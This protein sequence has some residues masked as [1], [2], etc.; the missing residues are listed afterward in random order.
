MFT[1]FCVLFLLRALAVSRFANLGHAL[2]QSRDTCV[3][4]QHTCLDFVK[5]KMFG[6]RFCPVP[7]STIIQIFVIPGGLVLRDAFLERDYLIVR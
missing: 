4:R 5:T 1:R 7:V 3:A 6:F 2:Y